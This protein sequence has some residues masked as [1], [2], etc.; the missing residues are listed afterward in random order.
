MKALLGADAAGSTKGA[1]G[2]ASLKVAR[3]TAG[4]GKAEPGC[5]AKGVMEQSMVAILGRVGSISLGAGESAMG[6]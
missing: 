3:V 5:C 4:A 2:V 6:P 1:A